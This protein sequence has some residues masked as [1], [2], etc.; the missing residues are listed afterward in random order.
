MKI[1]VSR[2]D[3][4]PAGIGGELWQVHRRSDE[5]QGS[6]QT[7]FQDTEL[8]DFEV[9]CVLGRDAGFDREIFS[10]VSVDEGSSFFVLPENAVEFIIQTELGEFRFAHNERRE[11]AGVSLRCVAH[12]VREARAAFI[13]GIMPVLDYFAY[14]A[15][16]PMI[17]RDVVTTDPK[18][19]VVQRSYSTPYHDVT[20]HEGASNL[21][22][23][24]LPIYG[25]YREAKNSLSYFYRFLCYFKILE[26]IYL[27]LRPE[28]FRQAKAAGVELDRIKELVPDHQD[29]RRFHTSLI[30]RPIKDF[31]DKELQK[32]FRDAAAHY[33]LD[34]GV[35]LN[36]SDHE[37]AAAFSNVILPVELCCRVVIRTQEHYYQQLFGNLTPTG[38]AQQ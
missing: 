22:R 24:L 21:R 17:V 31:F 35:P 29:L 3:L 38:A 33:L 4:A 20:I 32:Q 12:S 25:L 15:N 7:R 36:P 13:R 34:S 9:F 11:L 27:H 10:A 16:T 37:A 1:S 30:G 8:R 14:L 23:E 26:G 19:K 18:N 6:G 28:T 5:P 2:D